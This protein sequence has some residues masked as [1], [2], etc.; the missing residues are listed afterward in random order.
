[1]EKRKKK[2]REKGSRARGREEK[3]FSSM[4]WYL[5]IC[6]PPPFFNFNHFAVA[7]SHNLMRVVF[8]LSSAAHVQSKR[9]YL[10]KNVH[11]YIYVKK[12]IRR[13]ATRLFK[14]PLRPNIFHII[15]CPRIFFIRFCCWAI[16][17]LIIFHSFILF[18][19]SDLCSSFHIARFAFRR[20]SVRSTLLLSNFL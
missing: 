20:V 8:V 12:V 4:F 1:M 15:F 6:P 10:Q 14:I 18:S 17:G 19:G 5:V 13:P 3:A 11:K 7:W 2:G 9:S 16:L